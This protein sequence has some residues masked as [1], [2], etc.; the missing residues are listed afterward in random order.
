MFVS[1]GIM[2]ILLACFAGVLTLGGL[3]AAGCGGEVRDT[4]TDSDAQS[5]VTSI[6]DCTYGDLGSVPG[7]ALSIASN[8]NTIF[9]VMSDVTVTPA[10]VSG[11]LVTLAKDRSVTTQSGFNVDPSIVKVGDQ[12]AFETLNDAGTGGAEVDMIS[13]TA[14]TITH[15]D[16][17]TTSD[18]S[19][20]AA[21]G[22]GPLTTDGNGGI[23]YFRYPLSQ[24]L[25]GEPTVGTWNPATPGG[26]IYAFPSQRLDAPLTNLSH[27]VT[28]GSK[29]F[30]LHQLNGAAEIVQLPIDG[31]PETAIVRD[32][33]QPTD[34]LG[35]TD[36][37]IIFETRQSALPD[38]VEIWVA[39]KIGG[40]DAGTDIHEY[41]P[42]PSGARPAVAG[43]DVIYGDSSSSI[44]DE[45]FDPTAGSFANGNVPVNPQTPI[46]AMTTDSCGVVYVTADAS[47]Q[48]S[49]VTR[50]KLN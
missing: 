50:A 41:L 15:L 48:N 36:G 10:P 3:V 31:A 26:A 38:D 25:S 7:A 5:G 28:D 12:I 30:A 39:P 42:I 32:F 35:L 14:H 22:F 1:A 2:R 8:G 20:E 45:T 27:L 24:G 21:M 13:P 29:F 49:N 40:N 47:G 6:G 4:A 44:T 19:I 33:L 18:A 23:S 9:L 43:N 34:V 37:L 11:Q 17:V 46:I 16:E